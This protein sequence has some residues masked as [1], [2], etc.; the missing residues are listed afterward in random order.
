M[1]YLLIAIIIFLILGF[2]FSE[3]ERYHRKE[4]FFYWHNIFKNPLCLIAPINTLYRLVSA[5]KPFLSLN[6]FPSHDLLES[7]FDII[8]REVKN[9]LLG[10]IPL[11]DFGEIELHSKALANRG[12]KSFFIK[13]YRHILPAADKILPKTSALIRQCPEIHLAMLSILESGAAIKPHYGPSKLCYRYHL[14]IFC[15]ASAEAFI[16]INGDKYFWREGKAVLFDDTFSHFAMNPTNKKRIILF[17]DIER[18][19]PFP[20]NYF[21]K[22]FIKIMGR[23]KHIKAMNNRAMRL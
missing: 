3:V 21:N 8:Q 17:C 23:L 18:K 6:Y 11:K 5:N 2:C 22:G 13:C 9:L 12:W 20:F 10:N 14:T 4:K 16:S 19:L 7:N 1:F 15:D